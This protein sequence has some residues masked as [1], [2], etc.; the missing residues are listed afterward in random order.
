MEDKEDILKYL[1]EALS[2]TRYL[3]DEIA[4]AIYSKGNDGSEEVIIRLYEYNQEMVVNVTGD[5][6][7]AMI[8]DVL[9]ALEVIW[10]GD[11]YGS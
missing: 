9:S 5:S 11:L 2:R 3:K 4:E 10:W 7:I 1:I 6:G 8:K